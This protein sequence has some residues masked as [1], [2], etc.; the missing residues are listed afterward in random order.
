MWVVAI[1]EY[2]Y[3]CVLDYAFSRTLSMCV[4]QDPKTLWSTIR[5]MATGYTHHGLHQ[6]CAAVIQAMQYLHC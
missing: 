1:C 4:M 2:M 3:D 6:V 5:T